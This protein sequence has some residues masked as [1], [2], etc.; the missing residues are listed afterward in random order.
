MVPTPAAS[1][2]PPTPEVFA[3]GRPFFEAI[4]EIVPGL[5]DGASMKASRVTA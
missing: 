5:L 1:R 2:R 3:D 4:A